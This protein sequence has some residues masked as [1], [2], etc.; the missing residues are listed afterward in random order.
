[1]G[2]LVA[3][4]QHQ[5]SPLLAIGLNKRHAVHSTI[6]TPCT[7]SGDLSSHASQRTAFPTGTKVKPSELLQHLA[8]PVEAGLNW[9]RAFRISRSVFAETDWGLAGASA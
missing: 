7:V 6:P 1:M 2:H 3:E 9:S 4:N 5:Q 8:K